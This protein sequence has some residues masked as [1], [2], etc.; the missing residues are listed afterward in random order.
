MHVL[1]SDLQQIIF[2]RLTWEAIP[3]HDP[4]LVA[5]FIA[6]VL[7]GGALLGAVTYYGKW[8]YLWNEWFTSVDHKRIGIMYGILAIVM[9]LRGFADAIMMLTQKAIAFGPNEGYLP[10]HHFDQVFTAHGV[11]MIFFFA[12]PLITGGDEL[13]HAAADRRPRRRLPVPEQLQLLDDRRRGD[14]HHAVPVRRRVRPHRMAGVSAA[15]GGGLQS[16][17]GRRL[18]HMGTTGSRRRHDVIRDKSDRHDRED[19]RTGHDDDEAARVHL[20]HALPQR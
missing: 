16:G 10:P 2:G 19:A 11:I 9:L 17:G 20:D 8:G 4:I 7:G 5:T 14:H 15:V 6:V 12:M 3:Y 18:L 13:R 1:E